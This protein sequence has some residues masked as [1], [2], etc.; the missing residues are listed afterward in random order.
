MFLRWNI[1]PF[2]L[3]ESHIHVAFNSKFCQ[4]D[5][6]RKQSFLF[7]QVL[8]SSRI[9]IYKLTNHSQDL[10]KKNVWLV[11]CISLETW[12]SWFILKTNVYKCQPG[13]SN[14]YFALKHEQL[15]KLHLYDA[16]DKIYNNCRNNWKTL[17]FFF[18]AINI[19]NKT[20]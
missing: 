12:N 7:C 4:T 20:Q 13:I 3:S 8:S 17:C 18:K 5:R 1:Q 6:G 16:F 14:W 2:V 15:M 10:Y 11:F 9:K 19:Y